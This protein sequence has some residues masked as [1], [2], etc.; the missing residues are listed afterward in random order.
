MLNTTPAVT[1]ALNR[2]ERKT[3]ISSAGSCVRSSCITNPQPAARPTAMDA[4]PTRSMPVSIR[5]VPKINPNSATANSA[6]PGRSS[7]RS[8]RIVSGTYR[9]VMANPNAAM[10][11][12]TK[13]HARQPMACAS[14][15]P[16]AGSG[17]ATAYP[18]PK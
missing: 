4:R 17:V 14:A 18:T 13:K 5:E 15:P 7:R 16:S 2:L 1:A 8:A 3:R 12:T 9:Q 10:S 11:G 6:R